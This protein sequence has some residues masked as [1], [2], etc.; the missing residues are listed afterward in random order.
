MEFWGDEM[1]YSPSKRFLAKRMEERASNERRK[2]IALAR[3]IKD[4][5]NLGRGDPD[6]DTPAHIIEAA[7]RALEKGA[8]H[9]T[10]WAGL[11]ELR[12]AIAAKLKADNNIEVNPNDEIIVTV[13][14]QEA[15]FLAIFSIIN[16]GEE[17]IVPEPR[18]TPL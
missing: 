1:N 13:G 12:E 9:Y 2:M 17:I 14:A 8:T 5:I 16:P 11:P 18:Y 10:P 4:V 7:K 6:L 3:E 15:V